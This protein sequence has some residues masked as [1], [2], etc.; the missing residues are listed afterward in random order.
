MYRRPYGV[1]IMLIEIDEE[2]GPQLFK[3]DPAGHYC[4]YKGV[5]SGV[6]D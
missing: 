6:K 3:Y 5:A 4:G 1:E 2:L